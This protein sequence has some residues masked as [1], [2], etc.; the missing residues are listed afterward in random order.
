[1]VPGGHGKPGNPLSG[2]ILSSGRQGQSEKGGYHLVQQSKFF[3]IKGTRSTALTRGSEGNRGRGDR[4]E[5][6]GNGQCRFNTTVCNLCFR[7]TWRVVA[8]PGQKVNVTLLDFTVGVPGDQS[9]TICLVSVWCR[10]Y[11]V[12]AET[13]VS[14]VSVCICVLYFLEYCRS[15]WR[16]EPHYMLGKCVVPCP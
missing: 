2:E 4:L 9:H 11:G 14:G 12:C 3:L 16:P 1:M 7:C 5:Q 6:R 10:V 13:C 15:S 8:Q